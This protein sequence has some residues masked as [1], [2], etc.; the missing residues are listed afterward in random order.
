MTIFTLGLDQIKHVL[1]EAY[2]DQIGPRIAFQLWIFVF[3]F[4][5]LSIIKLLLKQILSSI[6]DIK[7]FFSALRFLFNIIILITALRRLPELRG[8]KG[9]R[10]PGHLPPTKPT[11]QPRRLNLPPDWQWQNIGS[12][13]TEFLDLGMPKLPKKIYVMPAAMRNA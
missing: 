4:E 7:M 12:R 5:N 11:I 6:N 13:R 3:I 8:Y 10:Y 2:Y 9:R 1:L